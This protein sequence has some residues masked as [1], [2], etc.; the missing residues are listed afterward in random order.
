M[1]FKVPIYMLHIKP[2]NLNEPMIAMVIIA[3]IMIVQ[4]L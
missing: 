3:T 2:F 1:P 4:R